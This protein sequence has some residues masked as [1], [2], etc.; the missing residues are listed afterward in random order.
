MQ[1]PEVCTAEYSACWEDDTCATCLD[2]ATTCG[3][4][5]SRGG[6]G[7]GATDHCEGKTEAFCCVAS[8]VD[9]CGDS[10]LFIEYTSE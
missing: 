9:G 8:T 2:G 5:G 1:G 3:G 6:G 4:G 7:G 10:G